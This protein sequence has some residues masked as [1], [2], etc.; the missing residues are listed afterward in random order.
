MIPIR[1]LSPT[2]AAILMVCIFASSLSSSDSRQTRCSTSPLG[3]RPLADVMD[4]YPT[5]TFAGNPLSSF[6]ILLVTPR[7]RRQFSATLLYRQLVHFFRDGKVGVDSP[8]IVL[9]SLRD[10]FDHVSYMGGGGSQHSNLSLPRP[11]GL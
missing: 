5:F 6:R 1:F 2:R 10:P 7:G 11:H 9:V 3:W 4:P 8:Q